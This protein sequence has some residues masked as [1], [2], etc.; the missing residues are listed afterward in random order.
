MVNVPDVMPLPLPGCPKH[1]NG[2][3]VLT[4]RRPWRLAMFGRLVVGG[5][6]LIDGPLEGGHC[7]AGNVRS[8]LLFK[9]RDDL[10]RDD[11]IKETLSC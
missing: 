2:V 5:N 9:E 8:S 4:H 1:L 10:T 6:P 11:S 7:L 3:E